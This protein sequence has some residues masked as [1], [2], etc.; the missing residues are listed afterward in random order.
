MSIAELR[1]LLT[2][3]P[4]TGQILF[5]SR[6]RDYF[7]SDRSWAT[8]NTRFAGTRA[9]NVIHVDGYLNGR[10]NGRMFKA[11]RVAWALHYGAWP[12]MEIDHINGD[13]TD[14]RISNLRDVTTL[15]NGKNRP[16][17]INNTS[18]ITGV[19]FVPEKKKWSARIKVS[20]KLIH[21][22]YFRTKT[23]AAEARRAAEEKYGFSERHGR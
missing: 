15:E 10:V 2:Y 13:K 12:T 3:N 17:Q 8:W 16:K 21:L 1:K 9:L 18:G 4:S 23:D 7:T 20:Q 5:E 6:P 19:A 14:N 11:H 22:G